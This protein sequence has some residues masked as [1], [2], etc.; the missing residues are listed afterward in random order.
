MQSFLAHHPLCLL[1]LPHRAGALRDTA[2]WAGELP[3]RQEAAAVLRRA[4][5]VLQDMRKRAVSEVRLASLT[6]P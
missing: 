6:K 1:W 2:P 3:T 5:P 4:L